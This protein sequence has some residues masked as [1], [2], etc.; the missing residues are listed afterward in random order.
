MDI[1]KANYKDV[2]QLN[3][4]LTL[5]IKDEKQYDDEID[6]NFVVTNMYE[7][8]IE[9]ENRCILVAEEKQNLVGYLYGYLCEERDCTKEKSTYKIAKLDALYVTTNY[10]QKGI[11]NTLI[12]NF[13]KWAI[14]K[15]VDG[16][17]VNVCSKN[18]KA[19]NLYQKNDF[20]SMKETLIMKLK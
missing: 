16:V 20:V 19:K 10:R 14:L 5:L 18:I 17:E 12:K 1:R 4:F 8:Y 11:G 6:E 15:K 13:K 3:W 2:K 9:D 7:N